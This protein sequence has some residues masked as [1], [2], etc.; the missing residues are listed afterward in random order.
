MLFV[1]RAIN[2]TCGL[3]EVGCFVMG[4]REKNLYELE[5][6]DSVVHPI[7]FDCKKNDTNDDDDEE[8]EDTAGYTN[9]ERASLQIINEA[10]VGAAD[11]DDNDDNVIG[12][13]DDDHDDHDDDC[14]KIYNNNGDTEAK[15]RAFYQNE[16]QALKRA[17]LLAKLQ[18]HIEEVRSM[19][20]LARQLVR[21]GKVCTIDNLPPSM[22]Q[23][24]II[25]DF[26]QNIQIP[27][28][29]KDQ[30]GAVYFLVPLNVYCLG[31][32]DYNSIE[33]H[34]H[35]YIYLEA[36]GGKGGNEVPPL[37]MKYLFD[38]G[39]LND[40]SQL[41]LSIIMENCSGQNKNHYVLHFPAYLTMNKYLER[42]H[43]IF[44]VAG[45]TKNTT[46][47]LFNLLELDHR[48]QMSFPYPN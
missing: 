31:I 20:K 41:D 26:C 12:V 22:M 3:R 36:E 43:I 42:V 11:D 48:K 7:E 30:P 29:L 18:K 44:L 38:K 1:V 25:V 37:I 27:S 21:L 28:F 35:A 16:E 39:Y 33:D 9:S 40:T 47:R 19:R 45:H 32:V 13:V 6:D 15:Y 14:N 24:V 5:A 23:V 2:L 4:Q 10:N 8:E 34:L 46:D 17:T